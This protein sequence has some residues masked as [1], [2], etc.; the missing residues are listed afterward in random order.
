MQ[1]LFMIFIFERLMDI[2]SIIL[3][4]DWIEKG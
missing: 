2:S 3:N 4:L 1:I